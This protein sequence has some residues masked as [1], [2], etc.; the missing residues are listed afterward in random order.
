MGDDPGGELFG[1]VEFERAG[2]G[3][4]GGALDGEEEFVEVDR[5]GEVIDGAVAHGFDGFPDI[6]VGGDEED[7]E[8]RVLLAGAAE[9][10][11]AGDAGHADVG[12]HHVDGLGAEG[13]EGGFTRVDGE[14]LEALSAQEGI[15]Q[16]ALA[17]VVIDDEEAGGG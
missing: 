16:A 14:G 10:I 3:D 6:G 5:F 8:D 4:A 12:D 2:V 1:L 15:E 17:G 9:G 7:R 13:G 11:E